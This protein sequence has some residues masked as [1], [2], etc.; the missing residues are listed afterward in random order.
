[1]LIVV[2]VDTNLL[3]TTN[4]TN[5]GQK[6]NIFNLKK[7][8]KDLLKKTRFKMKNEAVKTT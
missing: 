5:P 4:M 3:N 2:N 7:I 1:M 6:S 8:K